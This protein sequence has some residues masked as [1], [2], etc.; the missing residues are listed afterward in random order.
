MYIPEAHKELLTPTILLR[1][2]KLHLDDPP[3]LKVSLIPHWQGSLLQGHQIF[4]L[5]LM[6]TLFIPAH[7][8]EDPKSSSASN[9]PR[10]LYPL[11][12]LTYFFFL[13]NYFSVL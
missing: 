5:F 2:A 7:L 4:P 1:T 6:S 12:P 10:S 13:L 3:G 9:P 11:A 8:L